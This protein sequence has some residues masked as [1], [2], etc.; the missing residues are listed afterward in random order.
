VSAG[1]L[2]K[3]TTDRSTSRMS[4][5]EIAVLTSFRSSATAARAHLRH[6]VPAFEAVPAPHQRTHRWTVGLR[7]TD[8]EVGDASTETAG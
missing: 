2:L 5:T 3:L 8:R 4:F 1:V 6:A 7:H